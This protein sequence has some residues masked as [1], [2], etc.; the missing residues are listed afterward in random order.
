MTR[1]YLPIEFTLLAF[2]R[3]QIS[4]HIIVIAYHLTATSSYWNEYTLHRV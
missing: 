2:Y 4:Y 1:S 3:L